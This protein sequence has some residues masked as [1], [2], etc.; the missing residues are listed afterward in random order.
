MAVLKTKYT[1]YIANHIIMINI[2]QLLLFLRETNF[3]YM[4]RERKFLKIG[5]FEGCCRY[6]ESESRSGK[7]ES[8]GKY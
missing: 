2:A 1:L 8:E 4:K 5:S 3:F 7:R 6:V